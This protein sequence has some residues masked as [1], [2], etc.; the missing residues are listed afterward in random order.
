MTAEQLAQLRK[1]ANNATPGEWRYL[2]TTPFMDAEISAENY[3]RIIN[4][5]AGDVTAANSEFIAAFNPAVALALLDELERKDK[6]IAEMTDE[7]TASMNELSRIIRKEMDARREADKR[8]AEL[9]AISSAAEKLVRCKGRYHSEQNYRAL[10][11]L[12]GVTTPDLPPLESEAQTVTVKL[13]ESVIDAICLTAAEIHN[14]GRGVSD[15]RA[16][17]IINS[18]RCAAGINLTVEG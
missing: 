12:F 6:Q 1:V 16:Q 4:L 10:A 7:R 11:A 5:L 13:P 14:L 8:I 15:E 3:S 17:E 9:E 18:I 2:K